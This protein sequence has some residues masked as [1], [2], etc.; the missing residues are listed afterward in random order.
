MNIDG[1]TTVRAAIR[2]SFELVCIASCNQYNLTQSSWQLAY[3]FY[4][5]GLLRAL[6]LCCG[7]RAARD[8]VHGSV[9]D[10]KRRY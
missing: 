3:G 5:F 1:L 8:A 2:D 6:R 9:Q 7:T 10:Y 4:Q